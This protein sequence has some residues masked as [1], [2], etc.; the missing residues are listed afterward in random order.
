MFC[1]QY[2]R[3]L[4]VIWK[5]VM[6][7]VALAFSVGV[8]AQKTIVSG[9]VYDSETKEPLPFV[10]VAF[11]DSKIGTTTDIEGSYRI[12]TYYASDSIVASF[13]GYIPNA[14][15]VKR[16]E[17]QKIDIYLSPGS[18]SLSEVVVNAQ[19]FENP[20][21]VILKKIIQ[22]KPI[23]NRAKLDAYEYEVYN[24]IQFDLN[25]MSEKFKNRKLFKEFDFIFDYIDSSDA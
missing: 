3:V 24:N 20:A 11:K 23:N 22:N 17:S 14:Y 5:W 13:V 8:N 16:D 9:K 7:S 10:N 4:S 19:D 1:E 25:N 21:H 18:F 6:L 12:E 15:K 2:N